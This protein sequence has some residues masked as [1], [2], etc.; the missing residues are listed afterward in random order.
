[1][2]EPLGSNTK[3]AVARR[4]CCGQRWALREPLKGRII[5]EGLREHVPLYTLGIS[6]VPGDRWQVL[7]GCVTSLTGAQAGR[8]SS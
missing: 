6:A 7:H 5:P 8:G 3:T 1:M 4:V 2:R